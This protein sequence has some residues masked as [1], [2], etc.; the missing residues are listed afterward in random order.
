MTGRFAKSGDIERIAVVHDSCSA[1]AG[2]AESV[3]A[4]R[5]NEMRRS[6]VACAV[7]IA[8]G[9]VA[10]G[11]STSDSD[12]NPALIPS[13]LVAQV[14]GVWT[15]STTLSGVSEGECVGASLLAQLGRVDASAL[16]MVQDGVQITAKLTSAETGLTCTYAGR[17]TSN[18]VV[19][20][21]PTCSGEPTKRV[22]QCTNGT[23][24][25][26]QVIGSSIAAAVTGGVLT[27]SVADTF[28]VSDAQDKPVAGLV[29]KHS[30]QAT[31][32]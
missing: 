23:T 16:S 3:D 12:S 30:L 13:P 9:L 17:A 4:A 18:G 1:T 14:G 7:L 19:L 32:R 8:G 11:C 26:L 15:G 2:R 27:G 20:D 10:A 31:R 28:N 22:V 6:F 25:Q 5:S 21:A 29:V 24:R